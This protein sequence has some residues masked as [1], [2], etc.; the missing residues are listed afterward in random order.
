MQRDAPSIACGSREYSGRVLLSDVS[1]PPREVRTP[2]ADDDRR[3]GRDSPCRTGSA[4]VVAPGTKIVVGRRRAAAGG[5][6]G[7]TAPRAGHSAPPPRA[8]GPRPRVTASPSMG[9]RPKKSDPGTARRA[10]SEPTERSAAPLSA[11]ATRRSLQP[12][13]RSPAERLYYATALD[14]EVNSISRKQFREMMASHCGGHGRGLPWF[15]PILNSAAA[16]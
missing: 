10:E 13:P 5:P 12:P 8:P 1:S 9:H 2:A 3:D 15:A 6:P 16:C 11:T 4:R 7:D 14:I